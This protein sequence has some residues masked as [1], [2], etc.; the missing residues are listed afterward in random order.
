MSYIYNLT[1]TWNAGGTTFTAI[2]MNVTDTAS[3]SGSLL[4]DLQVGAASKFNVSK[5]G[6]V[7]AV[8]GY[9]APAGQGGYLT[10]GRGGFRMSADGVMYLFD[11]ARTSFNRIQLG[12]STISFP[13]LKRDGA[14]VQARLADDSAFTNIQ[15]K[16]T[17]DTAYAA[18]A[19]VAT[20]YLTLYDSNGTAYK[21][22][23]VAA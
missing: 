7:T 15:G 5:T 21:V 18:G 4:V 17:T 2:K 19:L 11:T 13:S 22:P 6:L 1:D 8:L 23:A 3:A 10:T 20:G 16:L 14:T 9:E 12:G